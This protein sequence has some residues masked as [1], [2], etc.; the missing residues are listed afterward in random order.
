MA[1]NA[2]W[3]K[4]AVSILLALFKGAKG[5]QEIQEA[6]GGSYTTINKRIVELLRAGLITEEYLTGEEF[7]ELP[8]NKRWIQITEDGRKLIQSLINSK[9]LKVPPL[10][11][12]REKWIILVLHVLKTVTGRTRLMKLLFLLRHEFG[13]RKGNYFRFEA[14]KYGP[15]SRG[16]IL[17]T[18]E[19]Q[20]EGFINIQRIKPT[21]NKFNEDEKILYLYA[22]RPRA[23]DIIMQL[24]VDL[25]D[26]T[27]K[28]L[29][30]LKPFNKMPLLKLLRY[31]YKRYPKFIINSII[32]GRV[33][34]KWDNVD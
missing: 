24:L 3:K 30:K 14:G 8:R 12:D 13:F 21:K 33:L 10:S 26:D 22:L 15:F 5:I 32:V 9:F 1:F 11:K 25:P 2:L 7:G 20:K 6:V 17:D 27:L 19:L 28:R 23:E 16:I 29:E 18:E 4:K 34:E 31:V